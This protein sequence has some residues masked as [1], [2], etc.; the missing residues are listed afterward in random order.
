M[1]HFAYGSNMNIFE[2]KKYL[3][4]LDFKIIGPGYLEDYI[5]TIVL[6]LIGNYQEKLILKK[7]KTVKCMG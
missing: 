7:E 2:L 6:S 3:C 1:Y 4:D 5:F